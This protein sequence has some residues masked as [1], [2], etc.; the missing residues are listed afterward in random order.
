M[1]PC[2]SFSC[3]PACAAIGLLISPSCRP[4]AALLFCFSMEITAQQASILDR[5]RTHDFQ[6]VAFPM[7]E[8]YVGV[9]RGNCAALLAPQASGG[10]GIF[11]QPTY[12]IGGNLSA[13]MLQGDGHYFVAKKDKLEATAERT[14]ELDAFAAELAQALLPTA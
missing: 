4:H 3:L 5:L 8:S 9:R 6:I 7:Y 10:F 13:K 2:S 11:G 14:N 12:L 1:E